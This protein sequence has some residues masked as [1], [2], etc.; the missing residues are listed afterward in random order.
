MRS[1][2]LTGKI[3]PDLQCS[4]RIRNS[5]LVPNTF[6]GSPTTQPSKWPSVA[7][8]WYSVWRSKRLGN[9]LSNSSSE[10]WPT[11]CRVRSLLRSRDEKGLVQRNGSRLKATHSCAR[12]K[13]HRL[14]M[15]RVVFVIQAENRADHLARIVLLFPLTLFQRLHL[16][17]CAFSMVRP[18]GSETLRLK[19]TIETAPDCARRIEAHLYKVVEVRSVRIA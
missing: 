3:S 1:K 7:A 5:L 6:P 12:G 11:R 18:R 13:F 10:A 8:N 15:K 14:L 4:H 9:L 17:I 2:R 19:V 16:E